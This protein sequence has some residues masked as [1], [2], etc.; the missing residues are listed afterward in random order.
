MIRPLFLVTFMLVGICLL[1]DAHGDHDHDHEHEHD[2][3]H[4]DDDDEEDEK[5]AKKSSDIP[6]IDPEELEYHKGSLCGYCEYCKV[7]ILL[8]VIT[9]EPANYLID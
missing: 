7:V 1:V 4:H 9:S 2:H 6:D 8:S 5:P 3:H